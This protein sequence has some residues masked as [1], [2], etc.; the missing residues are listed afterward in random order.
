MAKIIKSEGINESEKLLAKLGDKAFLKL[1]SY[2]NVYRRKGKTDTELCDMLVVF[3]KTVLI[4]SVK[5]K[6]YKEHKSPE[7]SWDRWKREAIDASIKSVKG[8]ERWIKEHP[9]EI[10]LDAK[11]TQKFPFNLNQSDLNFYKFIVANGCPQEI[12]VSYKGSPQLTNEPYYIELDKNDPIHLLTEQSLEALLDELS[13]ITDFKLFYQSKEEA[14]KLLE[15]L[16]YHRELDLVANYYYSYNEERGVHEISLLKQENGNLKIPRD[17]W[18]RLKKEES[19]QFMKVANKNSY[20]WDDI[21]QRTSEFKLDDAL[22]YT[23][24]DDFKDQSAIYDMAKE[25]RF[26]RRILADHIADAIQSFPDKKGSRYVRVIGGKPEGTVYVFLQLS[27]PDGKT[28]DESF[29]K[30]RRAHL[31]TACGALKNKIDQDQDQD[32]QS[33]KK[34]IGIAITAPRF[35]GNVNSEDMVSMNVVNWTEEQKNEFD[36]ANNALGENKYWKINISENLN[37]DSYTHFPEVSIENIQ[38]YSDADIIFDADN[39]ILYTKEERISKDVLMSEMGLNLPKMKPNDKCYCGSGIKYK[40][41]HRRIE[42]GGE[43]I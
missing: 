42:L 35:S 21:I 38:K 13:T 6:K 16:S 14:I 41:C 20:L 1:W 15:V 2:P 8:T 30:N 27:P 11:C 32:F 3:D 40:N 5:D 22:E 43:W 34:I 9:N 39:D 17:E 36:K 33:M 19:Y 24:A 28:Q 25:S 26:N 37:R 29:R 10:Y 7:V 4:F 23:N 18:E 31:L 12:S